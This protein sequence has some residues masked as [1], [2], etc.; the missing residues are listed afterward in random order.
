MTTYYNIK[1][2]I[3]NCPRCGRQTSFILLS[4]AIDEEGEFYRCQ[5]CSWVFHYTTLAPRHKTV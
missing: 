3:I 5:H 1:R 2:T 4:D